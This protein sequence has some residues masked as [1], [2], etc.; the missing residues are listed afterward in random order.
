MD[1]CWGS[2][3]QSQCV[4]VR[5]QRAAATRGARLTPSWAAALGPPLLL[6]DKNTKEGVGWA[7]ERKN[8]RKG[9]HKA[10]RGQLAGRRQQQQQEQQQEQAPPCHLTV[11]LEG[12]A[13]SPKP[14]PRRCP[15]PVEAVWVWWRWGGGGGPTLG[16]QLGCGR[17]RGWGRR[18]RRC[19]LAPLGA[20][21]GAGGGAAGTP[22]CHPPPHAPGG[23]GGGPQSFSS[24]EDSAGRLGDGLWLITPPPRR[25]THLPWGGGRP[26]PAGGGGCSSS[27]L[28]LGGGLRG[29]G[30]A[31]ARDLLHPL[32]QVDVVDPGGLHPKQRQP[33]RKQGWRGAL[34]T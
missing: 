5:G 10:Q 32:V 17:R 1:E 2:N 8:A 23:G 7:E 28:L 20:G 22:L 24:S 9:E 29:L 30:G 18:L 25:P 15:A 26:T 14:R 6:P 13:P 11:G 34:G 4:C 21:A 33:Q 16:C 19:R 3:V 27:L 12:L 31:V